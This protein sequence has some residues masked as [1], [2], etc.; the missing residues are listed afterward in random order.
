MKRYLIPIA[1]FLALL[2]FLAVGLRLNPREI[3]SPYIGGTCKTSQP[4]GIL[5]AWEQ[6]MRRGM[7]ISGKM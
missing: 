5:M 7:T 1:L 4:S 3:P 6:K 2:V